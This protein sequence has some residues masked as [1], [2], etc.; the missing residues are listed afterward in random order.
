MSTKPG[1][2]GEQELRYGFINVHG[3]QASG[4]SFLTP[5]A[6]ERV[7]GQ[8]LCLRRRRFHYKVLEQL[9]A[10][11]FPFTYRCCLDPSTPQLQIMTSL[12]ILHEPTQHARLQRGWMGSQDHT[13]FIF[14]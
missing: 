6:D 11:P 2:G 10:L 7:S 14:K 13:G 12:K 5:A 4:N 3:S 8:C 9:L 1:A